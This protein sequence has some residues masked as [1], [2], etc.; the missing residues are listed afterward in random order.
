M[1]KIISEITQGERKTGETI[2]RKDYDI[3]MK[4]MSAIFQK[5]AAGDV[6]ERNIN[7]TYSVTDRGVENAKE[8]CLSEIAQR[9]EEITEIAE[10]GNISDEMLI[11]FIRMQISD[12]KR[13]KRFNGGNR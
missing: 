2:L 11:D 6:I 5:L 9:F 12:R 3:N 10:S 13:F 7:S 4:Q 8:L 1:Y